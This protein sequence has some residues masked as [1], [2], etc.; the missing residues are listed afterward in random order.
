MSDK[1]DIKKYINIIDMIIQT[2]KSLYFI[3][4]LL[5]PFGF[6]YLVFFKE[7]TELTWF[8]GLISFSI[9]FIVFFLIYDVFLRIKKRLEVKIFEKF[10]H[11]IYF[12]ICKDFNSL[13]KEISEISPYYRDASHG[14]SNFNVFNKWFADRFD[15]F[16]NGFEKIISNFMALKNNVKEAQ[17]NIRNTK[18]SYKMFVLIICSSFILSMFMYF[19]SEFVRTINGFRIVY[20]SFFIVLLFIDFF[21]KV[22]DYIKVY[23]IIFVNRLIMLFAKIYLIR[24]KNWLSK[25]S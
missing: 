23:F 7:F 24:L 21:K 17:D 3:S 5:L 2:E 4:S 1:W 9:Y 16:E 8:S 15:S 22:L 12:Y 6:V 25:Q 18:T 10:N 11:F 14:T 20:I 13:K 19:I